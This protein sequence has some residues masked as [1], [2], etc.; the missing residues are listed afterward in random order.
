MK[1]AGI[2]L[3]FV[4]FSLTT[5][6]QQREKI[7]Y[8]NQDTIQVDTLS[9]IPNTFKA[10]FFF[11][12][13]NPIPKTQYPI[14]KTQYHL[15]PFKSAFIPGAELKGVDSISVSYY[16]YER[17]WT[18]PYFHKARDYNQIDP[19]I[20]PRLYQ[21][22]RN[23][24]PINR[25]TD[26][27]QTSGNLS[28]GLQIGST[29]DASLRS[30]LNLQLTGLINE[31][32]SIEAQLSDSNIPVQPEGN[33]Q[34]IQ[35]FDRFYL[36][37]FSNQHQVL[38]G[39]FN[40]QS[41]DGHFM[42]L[43]KNLQGL[44]LQTK[45]DLTK[46]SRLEMKSRATAALVKGKYVR[47]KIEAIE[48]NQGPYRL[49]GKNG[50][51]YIQVIAGSE[52][53]WVDGELLQRGEEADYVINYNTAELRFTPATL[54]TKDKRITASYEYTERSYTRFMAEN[55]NEWV[56][57]KGKV[58]FNLYT[59]QDA[60]NQPLLQEL[61]GDQKTLLGQIGDDLNRAFVENYQET[62]YSNDRVLYKKIDTLI[63][64]QQYSNVLVYSNTPDSAKYQAGFSFV[65]L[66]HGN[67]NPVN[68]AANGQVYQWVAPENGIPQ[69]SY[70]PI[71][72]LISPQSKQ[73]Y[74]LGGNLQLTEKMKLTA[75]WAI[76]G[77]DLNTFSN[78]DS[79]DDYGSGIRTRI[80]RND[81][82]GSTGLW[83]VNSF[84]QYR[85]S[86]RYFDPIERY[87][88]VEY[89]RDW[90]IENQLF[91]SSENLLQAG[92][93]AR[94]QDSLN[95][96]YQLDY[97][98][99]RDNYLALKQNTSGH[100]ALNT[101]QVNWKASQLN[102]SDDFRKT[103]FTRHELSLGK[104][105]KSWSIL[106]SENHEGNRWT[107]PTDQQLQTGSFAF[108]EF[109]LKLKNESANGLPW[110]INVSNRTDYLPK[111]NEFISDQS[112][113]QAQTGIN[114]VGKNGHS[115][116][117]TGNW[118][119]LKPS[120][121]S[122]NTTA[123]EQTLTARLEERFQLFKG[124]LISSTFYEIGS[125]LERKQEFSYLEVP[126]GQGYYT[127]TD[128][129]GNQVKELDEFDPAVFTD[130]AN[131]IR[132]FR[133]G[134]DYVPVYANRFSQTLNILPGR[135][136]SNSSAIREV[137]NQV[138]NRFAVS[139]N[140][141]TYRTELLSQLNPFIMND[142]LL[143]SLQAQLRNTLSFSTK[144]NVLGIDY[145]IQQSENQNLMSYGTEQRNNLMHGLVLRIKPLDAIWV[146]NQTS[147]NR[148]GQKSSFFS[149]RNYNLEGWKNE[150]EATLEA[151]QVIR[152]KLSWDWLNQ[153]NQAGNES[154]IEHRLSLGG[155]WQ[156][157]GKG[158][159]HMDIA[160]VNLGFQGESDSP[161]GYVMLKG[162]RPGHNGLAN[163]GIRRRLNELIQLDLNY[164]IRISEEQ[165]MI[166]TGQLS[167]RAI[168]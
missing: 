15:Y 104:S 26:D 156:M 96:S 158:Q 44:Q 16:V 95:A 25:L 87:K 51:M 71:T 50:E 153:T 101:W 48:G 24:T 57:E 35:D 82:L 122:E 61:S 112:A 39:D 99:Y 22:E 116:R 162:L 19:L 80:D 1:K 106:L 66:N 120:Q 142:S 86:G 98:S 93:I 134:T 33:T 65:G 40:L 127:W 56:F 78:L 64:G 36:R 27:L 20:L 55:S 38:A 140:R 103:S 107:L 139:I 160:Y 53:I 79:Q 47:T 58:Y 42:K 143:V 10:Y 30:N 94:N 2:I 144:N 7:L 18:V 77:N 37:L 28:R 69:G 92:I 119:N 3:C 147:F 149:S 83:M 151:G 136:V 128:Y 17:N 168:F 159:I 81:Q 70:E 8:L 146:N 45:L 41:P 62:P 133:P 97:L 9:I 117:F 89:E 131:Y 34:Q 73:V 129:N 43:N 167:V 13:Q 125:G 59:E 54:I 132:I 166:H 108:Q 75:E 74:S 111:A 110:F 29:Q 31:E 157:P 21:T 68:S 163:L 124:G 109:A 126:A 14:P 165:K 88:S 137:M 90:N 135:M 130:Q 4:I 115:T 100:L 113:W 123:P 85:R 49:T 46:S 91:N 155:D 60:R 63:N 114:L 164:G 67:Y 118:R 138:N 154:L 105:W 84:F 23:R 52:Q 12:T 76:S 5:F 32:F 72:R 152:F 148:Q 121:S 102:S 11:Q 161:V 150:L 145:L 141:K 6:G